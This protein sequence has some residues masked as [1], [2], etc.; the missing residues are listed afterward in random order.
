MENGKEA[1]YRMARSLERGGSKGGLYWEISD[2]L[3]SS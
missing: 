1:D 3:S 2:V